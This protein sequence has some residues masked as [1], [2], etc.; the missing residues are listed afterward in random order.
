MNVAITRPPPSHLL[1][2]SPHECMPCFGS[3]QRGNCRYKNTNNKVTKTLT[4]MT[5]LCI[6]ALRNKKVAMAFFDRLTMEMTVAVK[7]GCW[8]PEILIPWLSDLTL[9]LSILWKRRLFDKNFLGGKTHQGKVKV[10]MD[11]RM[12][13]PS[14]WLFK[15]RKIITKSCQ[16]WA[17]CIASPIFK[18]RKIITTK[19]I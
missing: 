11:D 14:L 4:C 1:S 12:L 2:P 13:S 5:F 3:Q 9:L 19:V 17:V 7:K 15:S 6:I 8:D 16:F 18:S 10:F